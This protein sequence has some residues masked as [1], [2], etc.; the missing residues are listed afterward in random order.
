[1]LGRTLCGVPIRRV[2]RMVWVLIAVCTLSALPWMMYEFKKADFSVH[3]Q[4]WFMAGIFVI[5]AVSVSVYEVAMHLEYYNCPKL[6]I[7][8]VQHIWPVNKWIRPWSMGDVF[9]WETKRG[10]LS[11]VIARPLMAAISVAANIAGVYCEGEFKLHCVYPYVTFVN[12]CS[13]MWALYCLVLLYEATNKELAPIR[14]L[15]KFIAIKAVVFL[16]FWQSLLID[17]A[18]ETNLIHP[19]EWSTYDT[20]DVAAGLQN[21]L[22]CLEMFAA[23]LGH[24][25]AFPPR[26]YMDPC[27]PPAGFMNNIKA[28]FDVGDVMTDVSG[29][30]HGTIQE[31]QD[32]IRSQLSQLQI[33]TGLKAG[34]NAALPT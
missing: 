11:Y 19:A 5:L 18:A 15:P 17:I 26:D 12:N 21:F 7:R 34:Q 33:K 25:Y 32:N 4:A 23:A 1:M 31:T 3:Y 2:I 28:M 29:L 9:F 30:V 8:V 6:Q 22:I 20:G 10:V 16:T 14:P 27:R 24:A 13:Q